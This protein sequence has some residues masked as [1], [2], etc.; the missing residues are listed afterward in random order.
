MLGKLKSMCRE[1]VIGFVGKQ[2]L[3]YFV[4]VVSLVIAIIGG[5]PLDVENYKICV[6]DVRA[7]V[8][9]SD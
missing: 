5:Q 1:D 3:S 7:R 9:W 6:R 2:M 4:V 8:G